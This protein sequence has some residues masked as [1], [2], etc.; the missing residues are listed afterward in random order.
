MVFA[1]QSE[2][3]LVDCAGAFNNNGCEGFVVSNPNSWL[4]CN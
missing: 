1:L 3:Q 2:Q 4:D